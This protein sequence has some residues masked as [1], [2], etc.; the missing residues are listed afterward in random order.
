VRLLLRTADRYAYGCYAENRG[1]ENVGHSFQF[2]EALRVTGTFDAA[3]DAI[4]VSDD[5]PD[6]P[7][8]TSGKYSTTGRRPCRRIRA[9]L[10]RVRRQA[11]RAAW[12]DEIHYQRSFARIDAIGRQFGAFGPR[13][14]AELDQRTSNLTELRSELRGYAQRW[15]AALVDLKAREPGALSGR[16]ISAGTKRLA[17]ENIEALADEPRRA[18]R[19]ELL[20]DLSRF[21][22]ADAATASR[23]RVLR[24]MASAAG[25]G[26]YR[27]E[28]RIAAAL[29]MRE[30][31]GR[32]AGEVYIDRY[33]T[34][35]ERAAYEALRE[36][37]A[38]A[39]RPSGPARASRA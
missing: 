1:K 30:L 21:T 29:R 18:L 25:E 5:T 39:L 12:A 22:R 19:H 16:A 37:E 11:A 3:H 10:R 24:T 13:T 31:L 23:L 34:H 9:R 14:V 36:C 20:R 27:M 38:F 32:I 28:T 4:L 26:A 8:N 6:V 35:A 7:L 15:E 17:N 2:L 33:A